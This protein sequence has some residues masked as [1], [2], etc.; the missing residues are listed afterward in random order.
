MGYMT[1]FSQ[2]GSL[3]ASSSDSGELSYWDA[4]AGS[5]LGSVALDER[6]TPAFS[7]D[8][9]SL[10][11]AGVDGS[12]FTWNLDPR[13][14]RATACRLAGRELTRAEWQSYLGDRPY[15]RVCG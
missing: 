2:D 14:W 8:N 5:L 9:S 15:E 4:R 1:A 12:V 6:G 7:A 3:F 10:M 11:L 13:A